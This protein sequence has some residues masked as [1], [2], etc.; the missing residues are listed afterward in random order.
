MKNK[1]LI[2]ASVREKENKQFLQSNRNRLISRFFFNS[3]QYLQTVRQYVLRQS[4]V[5]KYFLL[6]FYAQTSYQ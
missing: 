3:V 4:S 1:K 6:E 2:K 5:G